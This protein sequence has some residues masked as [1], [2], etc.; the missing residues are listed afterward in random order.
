ME[1]VKKKVRMNMLGKTAI[2]QFMIDD[3]YNVPDTRGDVARVVSGEGVLKV[4]EIKKVENYLRVAGKLYFK[5]LYVTDAGE[6][7]LASLDGKIPFEEM[8]YMEEENGG[9]YVVQVTRVEFSASVIHSRKLAIK[10]VV[11]LAVHSE[12]TVDE[13]T[14]VDV[15]DGERILKKQRLWNCFSCTP[16]RET[17]T[18]SRKK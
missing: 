2:D 5:V 18:G 14:T 8:I 7:A 15:E 12:R 13:E 3:D 1:L 17:Y 9:E 16:I 6:P 10:T 11:E 4:E